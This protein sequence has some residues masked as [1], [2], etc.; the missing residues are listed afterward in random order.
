VVEYKGQWYA[1]YHNKSVSGQGNLRSVCADKLYFNPDG[2]IKVVVQTGS[3]KSN[4]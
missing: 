1:F 3:K 2:T 4:N